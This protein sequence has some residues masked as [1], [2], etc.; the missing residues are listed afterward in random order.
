MQIVLYTEQTVS[1]ALTA[2]NARMQ[3]KPSSSRPALDGWVEKNGAFSLAVTSVVAGRFNRTTRLHGKLE[4]E[5]GVTVIRG[6]VSRGATRENMI[7]IFG[8]IAV[9]ALAL[10]GMGSP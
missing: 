6:Q 7:I 8:V 9:M 10:V 5:G 2:L 3:A 4:R 1:Q